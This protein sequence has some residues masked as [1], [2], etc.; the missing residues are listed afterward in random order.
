MSNFP[1]KRPLPRTDPANI[2][3]FRI[4]DDERGGKAGSHGFLKNLCM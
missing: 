3:F 2:W 4:L 1:E